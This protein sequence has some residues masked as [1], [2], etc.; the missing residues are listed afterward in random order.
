MKRIG[1]GIATTQN[2]R[3]AWVLVGDRLRARRAHLGLAMEAVAEDLGVEPGVYERYEEGRDQPPAALLAEAAGKFGVPLLWFFQDVTALDAQDG[4]SPS[5]GQAP[6]YMV[7]TPDERV[8]CMANYFRQLDF[9]GQQHLLTIAR[10]LF[11][12]NCQPR[13]EVLQFGTKEASPKA[14]PRR[15]RRNSSL[16]SPSRKSN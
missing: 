9:A 10:A 2:D 13:G 14:V 11:R 4:V 5:V 6:V 15:L 8:Q 7:A 16:K 1:E 12:T 3:S